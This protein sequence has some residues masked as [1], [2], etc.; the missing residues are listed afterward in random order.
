MTDYSIERDRFGRPML[1]P[2]EG[3]KKTA[4]TR[5]STM[6]KWLD[7]KGGLINWSAS[8]A[9]IG[10]MKSKPLQARVSAIVARSS[11]PYRENKAALKELVDT[12]TQLAQ[13]Q[14]RADYGTAIHEFAEL[15]DQGQLAWDY[16]PEAL[17]GPLEAYREATQDLE[18]V[19]TEVFVVIDEEREG[20]KIR[21]AGSLDRVYRHAELGVCIG[22]LKTGTDEPKYPLGVMTQVA[23]YSRGK[24]YCDDS[25]GDDFRMPDAVPNAD[26]TAFR[27]PIHAELNRARGLL[28]HCPLEP[29]RGKHICHLY[30]LDL[31]KGWESLLLGHRVQS[32]RR[33][34]ALERIA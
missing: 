5:V 27:A 6:A 21:G 31:D 11:D 26:G 14:G 1:F 32:A 22:D 2:P 34:K 24:R 19:N 12:A 30:A 25:F 20:K 3:G 4:Y 7:D 10:L 23:G 33:P 16:V 29:V 13:A 9:M 8:M 17:K 15:L 18:T 28:V